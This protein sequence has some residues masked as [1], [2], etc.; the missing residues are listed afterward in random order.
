M[1]PHSEKYIP[2]ILADYILF[3]MLQFLHVAVIHLL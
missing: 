1:A 2:G 3:S